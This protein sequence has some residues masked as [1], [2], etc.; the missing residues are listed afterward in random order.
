MIDC[1]WRLPLRM[2]RSFRISVLGRDS[3]CNSEVVR[4]DRIYSRS[5]ELFGDSEAQQTDDGVFAVFPCP[6]FE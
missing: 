2:L 3:G 6:V 5:A 4:F 1:F